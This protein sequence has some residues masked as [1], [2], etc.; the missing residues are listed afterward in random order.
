MRG[1]TWFM[2]LIVFSRDGPS[3][4][5]RHL[6]ARRPTDSETS[7][8]AAL[9]SLLITDLSYLLKSELNLR[10]YAAADDS[11]RAS[12]GAAGRRSGRSPAQAGL[13]RSTNRPLT[14][15]NG[16]P[17]GAR[18][19]NPRIRSRSP[20][21][22]ACA[23]WSRRGSVCA[24]QRLGPAY[25]GAGRSQVVSGRVGWFGRNFGRRRRWHLA[26]V[27]RRCR[28]SGRQYGGMQSLVEAT[29][30]ATGSWA[31]EVFLAWSPQRER[32]GAKGFRSSKTSA[33]VVAYTNLLADSLIGTHQHRE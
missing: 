19:H 7:A 16:G 22:A 31:F 27:R 18:T 8:P 28:R 30:G 26:D 12:R 14:C 15:G 6:A 23:G 5:S 13:L 20:R 11:P 1:T 29:Q 4:A 33:A 24:G 2:P 32:C 21:V 9:T 3:D 17:R 25:R 10:L